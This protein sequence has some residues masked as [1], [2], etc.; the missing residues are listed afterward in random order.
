[1][2]N[3]PSQPFPP[4]MPSLPSEKRSKPPT[5][6][7]RHWRQCGDGR[8]DE[9]LRP[10]EVGI[11]GPEVA[12]NQSLAPLLSMR[13]LTSIANGDESHLHADRI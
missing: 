7:C 9:M 3:L 2:R 1:L 13:S 4:G 6:L 12:D 5:H 8:A 11:D 10:G